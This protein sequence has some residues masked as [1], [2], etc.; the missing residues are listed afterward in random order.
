M[1]LFKAKR[2]TKCFDVNRVGLVLSDL[3]SN[4]LYELTGVANRM[5]KLIKNYFEI[6]TGSVINT[7]AIESAFERKSDLGKLDAVI[8]N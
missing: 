4:K 5:S 1:L 6:Y 2:N 3:S 8:M 7:T